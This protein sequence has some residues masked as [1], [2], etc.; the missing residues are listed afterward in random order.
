M[1]L[2]RGIVNGLDHDDLKAACQYLRFDGV[3]RRRGDEMAT[4]ILRSPRATAEMLIGRL[5]EARVGAVCEA[6]G[7]SARGRGGALIRRLAAGGEHRGRARVPEQN[8]RRQ[9]SRAGSPW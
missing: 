9:N 4:A 1:N 7:V 3:D 2:E 6:I 8:E 5:G